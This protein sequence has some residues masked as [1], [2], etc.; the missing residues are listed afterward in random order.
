MRKLLH[1]GRSVCYRSRMSLWWQR[2]IIYQVYP[3]SF[4]DAS[5]DGV[6]DLPGVLS[7]LDYLSA[8][9]VDA[10][11]L[12]PIYPSPMKDFG[13]DVAD[14]TAVDPLFGTLED[15]DRLVRA[16]H[17]RSLKLIL[18][19]VP[20]HSSDEHPWFKAARRSR[21]DPKRDWYLWRDP[22]PDGGPPNN[23][24]SCFG[25]SAWTYDPH[26]AQ[27][28]YHAF[29]PGQPDLNWRN[30]QLA[31]AMLGVLRFWLERGVD[32]FRVDVLWHLV[33]HADFP[34]SPPNPAWRAGM[35]PYQ[36]L[37]PLHT[38]DLPE[39]Q[40]IVARMRRLL[41][42]YRDRVLIGEI[43]LPI[44]RLVKY[45]GARLEGAHLPFNFQLVQAPWDAAHIAR[46]IEEYERALP[47][48][49]WPNWVLGNHDQHR[50]ASRVG[51]A[52]ARGAAMLL[53][54]LRG[55]PTLYYGDE[56][57]MR[58]VEIP[59]A[60]VRDPFERN[61]PGRGLGRDPERTPMQWSAEAQA[62]FTRAAPWLPIA[63]D[64]REVNVETQDGDA[65]SML[66]LYRRLIRFVLPRA[67]P[68]ASDGCGP[69]ARQRRDSG[70]RRT[71]D[72]RAVSTA[73]RLAPLRGG[74]RNRLIRG[75][76]PAHGGPPPP[77][78]AAPPPG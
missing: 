13:Y 78:R 46:L 6:G 69:P 53:F 61:V 71:F 48:G 3:R 64:Y 77:A 39:V 54:T 31:E 35:D 2:G 32:G 10:L 33:K 76:G 21:D 5:G 9:G 15:F 40:D 60:L 24:L 30:P 38:T 18:D 34:D 1:S 66:P 62:G 12:S 68:L 56:I 72:A 70:R 43:Y 36:A 11:W 4:M 75:P 23:W 28:Y 52:Q 44:E 50:I 41:D 74:A 55:T 19:F 7:R 49:A 51:R 27:Y 25:G 37:V 47:E 58:D 20:N 59:A 16:A 67:G 45:Y 63:A 73:H 17:A 14:Y 42:E 57:G 8:L 26:T 29:L 22:A 65:H